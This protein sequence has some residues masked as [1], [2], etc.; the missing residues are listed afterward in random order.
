MSIVEGEKYT[1]FIF[2]EMGRMFQV[3]DDAD[4]FSR[5]RTHFL[6]WMKRETITRA[7]E[8]GPFYP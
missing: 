7:A 1:D 6:K 4:P 8:R 5:R 3:G 2:P